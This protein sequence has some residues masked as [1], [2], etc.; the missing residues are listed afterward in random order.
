MEVTEECKTVEDTEC[1]QMNDALR[2]EQQ[3]VDVASMQ[4]ECDDLLRQWSDLIQSED[5]E[6]VKEASIEQQQ[7]YAAMF[8]EYINTINYFQQRRKRLQRD[9]KTSATNTEVATDAQAVWQRRERDKAQRNGQSSKMEANEESKRGERERERQINGALRADQQEVDVASMQEECD[10]LLREWSDLIQRVHSEDEKTDLIEQQ[11]SYAAM[12]QENIN[13]INYS[14]QQLKLKNAKHVKT[15]RKNAE[16]IAALH[17]LIEEQVEVM[18]EAYREEMTQT[19]RRSQEEMSIMLTK[20]TEEMDQAL[21]KLWDEELKNLNKRKKKLE[22]YKKQLIGQEHSNAFIALDFAEDSKYLNKERE[23]HRLKFSSW[24]TEIKKKVQGD[25]K[26]FVTLLENISIRIARE[27]KEIQKLK[28]LYTNQLKKLQKQS[29]LSEDYKRC[30]QRYER[31]KEQVRQ[32]SLADARQ[33]EQVWLMVEGELKQLAGRALAIDKEISQLVFGVSWQQPDLDLSELYGAIGPWMPAPEVS[34]SVFQT[35][36]SRRGIMNGSAESDLESPDMTVNKEG[37]AVSIYGCPE[38]EDRKR[39]EDKQ[40]QMKELLCNETDFLMAPKVLKLLAPLITEE[41]TTVK[42]GSL[43]YTLGIDEKD[44]PELTDF[45]LKYMQQRTE[46]NEGAVGGCAAPGDAC[47]TSVTSSMSEFIHPNHILPALKSFFEQH[48]S[49]NSSAEQLYKLWL[50]HA[51]D[52]SKDAAYWEKLGNVIPEKKVQ[53]W[54]AAEKILKQHIAVLKDISDLILEN[55]RLK[56]QNME[57]HMKL[58][59]M[60][61]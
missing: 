27:E 40:N 25:L 55:E 46:Q 30:L 37:A 15:V 59:T 1:Q 6:D 60:S 57:L 20:D 3:E 9:L 23:Q 53:L 41:Q 43:L 42:L 10:D 18:T 56:Q 33:F 31:K 51:R 2:A 13:T 14:Q 54:D 35:R 21:T 28:K 4:E 5:S 52:T 36:K 39:S 26:R 47:E 24:K 8:Q 44:L 22:E 50:A 32:L 11:Q 48:N 38:W 34:Q 29:V 16:E 49:R 45:L 12:F 19:Q 61:T 7:M 58:N 17:A